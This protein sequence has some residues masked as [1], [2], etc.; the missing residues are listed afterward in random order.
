M[1]FPFKVFAFTAGL[2]L[3][4]AAQAQTSPLD[5]EHFLDPQQGETSALIAQD[6][7]SAGSGSAASLEDFSQATAVALPDLGSAPAEDTAIALQEA[8]PAPTPA[9]D[10]A[11][12]LQEAAPAPVDDTTVVLQAAAPSAVEDTAA[13][14][15]LPV[16]GRTVQAPETTVLATEFEIAPSQTETT[17]SVAADVVAPT[18]AIV[19]VG[20]DGAPVAR[21]RALDE[22]SSAVDATNDLAAP[23][24]P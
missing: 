4:T 14:L 16:P 9:E 10:T 15:D 1:Y 23:L 12:A 20:E 7:A 17:G 5:P 22:T 8:A 24:L 18:L 11:I 6:L 13:A 21:E 2:A 3:A 19:P